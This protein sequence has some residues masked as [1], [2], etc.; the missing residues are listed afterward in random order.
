MGGGI[1]VY[2]GGGEEGGTEEGTSPD[3]EG[4]QAGYSDSIL[5]NSIPVSNSPVIELEGHFPVVGSGGWDFEGVAVLM[6]GANLQLQSL[7]SFGANPQLQSLS[8]FGANLQLQSLSSFGANL[9]LQ[10][11]SSFGANL[12]LQSLSS[13]GANLQLQILSSCSESLQLQILS[14]FGAK[15]ATSTSDSE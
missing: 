3:L 7:S 14:S 1:A 8:S 2:L 4:L 11:L 6:T 10:S 9:Q 15:P 5:G 12:Q 13:F